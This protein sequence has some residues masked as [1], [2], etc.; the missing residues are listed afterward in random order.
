MRK[1]KCLTLR[2]PFGWAANHTRPTIAY[3]PR[4]QF[5]C[6]FYLNQFTSSGLEARELTDRKGIYPGITELKGKFI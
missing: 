4:K 2:S 1:K 6:L 5:I 3:F